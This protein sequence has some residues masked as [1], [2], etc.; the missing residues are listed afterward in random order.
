MKKITAVEDIF[1]DPSLRVIGIVGNP[2][3]AKSNTL[4]H[5]I[6]VLKTKY[7]KP[8]IYA[9]GLKTRVEGVQTINRI[10]ELEVIQ[11]SVV[12][13]DEFYNFL[14]LSN[15]KAKEQSEET[16]RKVYHSNNIIILVGV[17]HNYDKFLSGML[18]CVIFKQSNL[19]DFIQ[20]SS[21][22]QFTA[23]YSG[24]FEVQKASTVLA[25]PKNV[26]LVWIPGEHAYEV[27]IPYAEYG[28]SKRFNPKILVEIP[29]KK[30]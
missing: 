30:H 13:V 2:N 3:E 6:N 24:G 16:F 28:D 7:Q 29:T 8:S 23:S 17:P 27:E 20:R 10:N 4:Y 22:Q 26:A 14:R 25:M 18:Q 5:L 11:N 19:E 1:S 15:R 21:L 9:Y 12:I